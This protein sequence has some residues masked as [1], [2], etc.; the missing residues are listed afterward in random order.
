MVYYDQLTQLANRTMFKKCLD[1]LIQESNGKEKI[2]ILFLDLDG[3][4]YVNDTFGHDKGDI[5]LK[6]TSKRLLNCVRGSDI[7]VSRQGGD[8]FTILLNKIKNKVD[9]YRVIRR[10]LDSFKKPFKIDK[11]LIK[12]S[13]SIGVSIFPDD[14][15]TSGQLIKN[16]DVA[17]YQAKN[18][19][20]NTCRFY[21]KNMTD[22]LIKDFALE[23]D[24]YSALENKQMELYCQPQISL[25][26]DKIIGIEILLRWNHPEIGI[27]SP[28]EFLPLAEKSGIIADL[29]KWS[30]KEIYKQSL[31]L[32]DNNIKSFIS[33]NVSAS[34]IQKDNFV[35]TL[36]LP[37]MR[38][39]KL[40]ESQELHIEISETAIIQNEEI[41][42][43]LMNE[44][45]DIGIKLILDNF[46]SGYSSL[47]YLK[48]LPFDKIK[49]DKS[50]I[51][52]LEENE[53]IIYA[54]INLAHNL[55]LE[56]IA[57][58]VETKEQ[59]QLLKAFGCDCAQGYYI[60]KPIKF[61]NILNYLKKKNNH[62]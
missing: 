5:I 57:I 9:I 53:K 6:V 30:M 29:T 48:K 4:K 24:L 62:E 41:I 1:K 36:L 50:L 28:K 23:N 27:I 42:K 52:N 21:E 2:A 26:T 61:K 37:M 46:G 60:Q 55:G 13:T 17:M 7:V 43:I 58:G 49:I 11:K 14:G 22:K 45:K 39:E 47:K 20:K 35:E 33:L 15:F 12:L 31:L 56:A 59:L 34:Q 40:L 16:A 51:M 54:I 19:G 44:L 3:F 25:K 32:K 8:E 18:S 10:I 38:K